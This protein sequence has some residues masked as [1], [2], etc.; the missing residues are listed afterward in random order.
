AA[1][2]RR[3]RRP[4]WP[5][6]RVLRRV[7]RRIDRGLSPRTGGGVVTQNDIL[8][9][10]QTIDDPEMPISIVDLGIVEKI[11]LQPTLPSPPPQG[12]EAAVNVCV[13]ILPTFVGCTALSVIESE[14]RRRVSALPGVTA[15]DVRILYSPAWSV[16]RISVAGRE[17]LR[18]HGVTVPLAGEA[19][20]G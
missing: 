9:V 15:V 7:A 17:S 14:I 5:A 16:D 2:G 18:R 10:L 11:E 13:D 6:Q 3:D 8:K 4:A 1:K 12:Q 20:A 19:D